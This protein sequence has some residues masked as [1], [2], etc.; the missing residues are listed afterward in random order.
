MDNSLDYSTEQNYSPQLREKEKTFYD[1]NRFKVFLSTK[2]VLQRKLETIL[3]DYGM[4]P[5]VG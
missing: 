2:Q 4:D 1:T 3:A 5:W